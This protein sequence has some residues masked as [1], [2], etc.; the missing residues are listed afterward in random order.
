MFWNRIGQP[1][2]SAEHPVEADTPGFAHKELELLWPGSPAAAVKR[3]S[4]LG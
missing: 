3:D 1:L 4:A 2:R